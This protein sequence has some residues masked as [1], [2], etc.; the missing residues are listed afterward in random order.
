I[1]DLEGLEKA[2]EELRDRYGLYPQEVRNLLEIIYLKT[3]LKSLGIISLIVKG[4]VVV[5]RYPPDVNIKAKLDRLPLLYQRRLI[6]EGKKL[7]GISKIDLSG[8]NSPE[9]LK[10]LKEFIIDLSK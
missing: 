6:K 7:V 1:K 3:F 9:I 10:F 2:K 5:L 8:V 4:E